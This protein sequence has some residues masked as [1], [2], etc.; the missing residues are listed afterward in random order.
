VGHQPRGN[1]DSADPFQPL[2]TSE[3]MDLI[4]RYDPY[5]PLVWSPP[6]DA[7]AALEILRQGNQRFV[8]IVDRMHR[9]TMGE[10][11]ESPMVIPVNPL[12]LGLPLWPAVALDQ[13][14]F[15][16]VIGCSDA[17]APVEQIFD[18]SFN[19]LFVVRI[20]GN[21]LGTECLGSVDYAVR[22]M[23]ESV[24]F[25][26]VL[27]HSGCGAVTAAVDS[28]LSPN[29]YSEIAS[30][31]ALR[32]LINRV[33]IAVR[34]AAKGLQTAAGPAVADHPNYRRALIELAVYVNAAVTAFDLRRELANLRLNDMR[35]VY[36]VYD[37][38][39][40]RVHAEPD[41]CEYGAVHVARAFDDAP[42][43]ADQLNDLA[44]NLAERVIA[45]QLTT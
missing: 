44:R 6:A 4:Y 41:N 33:M 14:P 19:S 17:R 8:E 18:Q 21:V 15:G 37:L 42:H 45:L 32:S 23:A 24:K 36:G 20:A 43:E 34:S 28:Y 5:Q 9:A 3:I 29:D 39:S 12:S 27:G 40:M 35:V 25:V 26:L 22:T 13:A 16:L 10:T 38:E 2:F 7:E 30:N 31:H 1:N 11:V